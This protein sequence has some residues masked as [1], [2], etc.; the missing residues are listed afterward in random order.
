MTQTRTLAEPETAFKALRKRDDVTTRVWILFVLEEIET[1]ARDL[2][3]VAHPLGFFCLPLIR[4]YG[5][6]LCLH[7]WQADGRAARVPSG[8][9]HSHNWDLLSHLLLGAMSN[10]LMSVVPDEDSRDELYV[11]RSKASGDF[12]RPTGQRVRSTVCAVEQYTAGAT[13]E[14]RAGTFHTTSTPESEPVI[15]VVVGIQQATKRNLLVDRSGRTARQVIRRECT[16]AETRSVAC[17]IRTL[18]QACPPAQA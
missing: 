8:Q 7:Y 17:E 5:S 1:H 11:V 13:Y 12:I 15:T 4:T 9:V 18:I 3:A 16:S 10:R 6:G 14:M 2:A